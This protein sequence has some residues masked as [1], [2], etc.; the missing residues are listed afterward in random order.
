MSTS[1]F[2]WRKARPRE[3]ATRLSYCQGALRYMPWQITLQP[4]DIAQ[5][6]FDPKATLAFLAA[7][8]R[9]D[10][11]P[12][13]APTQREC[14]RAHFLVAAWQGSLMRQPTWTSH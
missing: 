5:R 4:A 1:A 3:I 6:Q 9:L 10:G 8:R 14:D 11:V 13:V 7:P 2:R 12:H